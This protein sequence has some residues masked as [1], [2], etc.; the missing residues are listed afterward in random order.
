MSESIQT[1]DAMEMARR[2]L[3]DAVRIVG[4]TFRG[5]A[6]A[7]GVVG[8]AARL[9]VGSD[10][11]PDAPLTSYIDISFVPE[12]DGLALDLELS[13]NRLPDVGTTSFLSDGIAIWL[14]G[15]PAAAAPAGPAVAGAGRTHVLPVADEVTV[16]LHAW[17]GTRKG[18]LS[19]LR[20]ATGRIGAGAIISA[21]A[22]KSAAAD[23][24][25]KAVG[26]PGTGNNGNDE[27]RGNAGHSSGGGGGDD[28]GGSGDGPG[29]GA[30]GRMIANDDS[31]TVFQSGSVNVDVTGNDIAPGA[32]VI[33]VTH[34][35]GVE[36]EPGDT[37]TLPSGETVTLEADGTLTIVADSD[38]GTTSF[39]YTAA[40]G[41][42]HARHASTATVTLDT[43]PCFTAGTM[44]RTL[45]G[46]VPV[47]RLKV[48]E[49]VLTRDDGVQ[50]VRWIGRRSMAAEGDM[51]PVRIAAG[52]FG[53]HGLLT[54]S[55]LHRILVR[56]SHAELLFGSDEV[57]VA[58]RDLI[59]GRRVIRVE[60]GTV[61]YV[62]ILFDRH[63]ILWSEGLETESFL[64]GPQTTHCFERETVA[65]IR[66]IFPEIDPETGEGY[67]PA[68]RPALR[69]YE[70]RVL[71]A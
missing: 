22:V 55:P 60:G 35:N 30:S 46:D 62:H 21:L 37:I 42:G 32:S 2:I 34:I 45:R 44:I 8:D 67:G 68:A 39:T 64:P 14:D 53:E 18:V 58:A 66:R 10:D 70:A 31:A 54:V 29:I 27:T 43:V 28:G 56:N 41:T 33:F 12:T 3:G 4:A 65:E 19:T 20:L 16:G 57:L 7:S 24:N 61:E 59:D 23:N 13:A 5:A 50:E 36:V 52:T 26:N 15:Q 51:A 6:A 38:V 1:A 63:Q 9:S 40:F 49:R 48:G 17:L 11:A 47:E 71:V 69:R 25:G